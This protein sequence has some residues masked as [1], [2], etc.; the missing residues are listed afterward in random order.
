MM[1]ADTACEFFKRCMEKEAVK[2]EEKIAIL[3]ELMAEKRAEF[4]S[5]AQIEEAV[6]GKKVLRINHEKRAKK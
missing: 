1:S 2:P 4:L 3:N 5:Q 6:K